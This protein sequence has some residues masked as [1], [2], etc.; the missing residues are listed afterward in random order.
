[1]APAGN[2]YEVWRSRRMPSVLIA[3]TVYTNVYLDEHKVNAVCEEC[4]F[5]RVFSSALSIFRTN[6]PRHT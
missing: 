2:E 3:G 4:G 1:M 5:T 6:S